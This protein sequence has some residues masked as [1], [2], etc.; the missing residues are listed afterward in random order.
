MKKQKR[1]EKKAISLFYVLS[2]LCINLC[3]FIKN[4][5]WLYVIGIIALLIYSGVR[6]DIKKREF[7]IVIAALVMA[8]FS[9]FNNP[10]SEN[11]LNNE[12]KY[13]I[14]LVIIIL[15]A[16]SKKRIQDGFKYEAYIGYIHVIA[17]YFFFFFRNAYYT[18]NSMFYGYY[19]VGTQNG[20]LGYT[21]ALTSHFSANALYITGCLTALIGL[22]VRDRKNKKIILAIVFAMGA[23]LLTGKRGHI[24]FLT[25]ACYFM[26]LFVYRK[27]LKSILN[28]TALVILV[29]VVLISVLS[30]V[31]PEMLSAI[32]RIQDGDSGR[33]EY[34]IQALAWF[35][36]KP[37][38]GIGWLQFSE[39]YK[40]YNWGKSMNAHNVYIQVLTECGILGLGFYLLMISFVFKETL[41]KF[42]TSI[43]N[44]SQFSFCLFYSV[45][46]QIFYLLYSLTGNCLYDNTFFFYSIAAFVGLKMP[47]EELC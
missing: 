45:L 6:R 37:I 3:E 9:L 12:L 30:V 46:V 25:A 43:N 10:N 16:C 39:R 34:W 5:Y 32:E 29:F 23:L 15:G 21:A 35:K 20:A 17:T 42:L 47:M 40:V 8:L 4:I 13:L 27:N 18:F 24:F 28:K 22:W 38:T 7:I 26:M 44:N 2:F 31:M 19:P 11:T 33:F 36:E 14:F 41:V 1:V